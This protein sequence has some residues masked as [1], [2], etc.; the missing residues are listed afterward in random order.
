MSQMTGS[1]SLCEI[2]A[3]RPATKVRIR[4]EP[5][6]KRSKKSDKEKAKKERGI[7]SAKHIRIAQT[8]HQ[9]K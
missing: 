3:W 7:Y 9:R 2:E 1:R 8:S 6:A 4:M 5:T